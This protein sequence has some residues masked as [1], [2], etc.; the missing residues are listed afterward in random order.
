[1]DG[2]LI[3]PQTDKAASVPAIRLHGIQLTSERDTFPQSDATVTKRHYENRRFAFVRR[4]Q[5]TGL[6]N[7]VGQTKATTTKE[8]PLNG[9]RV[10]G[11]HVDV[12]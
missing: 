9:M 3:L 10:N 12:I 2:G 6:R 8:P 4:S 11:G 1:M 7:S 5:H